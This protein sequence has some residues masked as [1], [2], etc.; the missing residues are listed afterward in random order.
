MIS[1]PLFWIT[2][3]PGRTCANCIK[4]T[5]F[6]TLLSPL[7]LAAL[8]LWSPGCSRKPSNA[9]QRAA[10]SG[11]VTLDGQPL[12]AG[13]V[14]FI[15]TDSTTGPQTTLSV[16]EGAFKST[17]QNGPLVGTHRIEI[18]STD[19]GGFALDDEQAFERLRAEGIKKIEAVRVPSE[20]N[21]KSTLREVVSAGK[22]EPFQFDLHSTVK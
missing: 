15:P 13:V 7:L 12:K 19:D 14:R 20:F 5:T 21:Q 6:Q 3:L 11:S 1:K 9:P 4:V 16:E 2:E 18:E 10:V 8:V 22:N 17:T